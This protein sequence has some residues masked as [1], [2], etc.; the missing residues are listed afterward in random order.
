MSEIIG[1]IERITFQSEETGYTVAQLKLSGKSSLVC[2]VGAMPLLIPGETVR[3]QGE[4]KQHLVHGRQF[5]VSEYSRE[6]PADLIGIRK[7]LGSG[8]VKGIG[9]VYAKRITDCFGKDTLAIIDQYP[10]KLRDVPG[11][12]EKRYELIIA[13]W[14]EQR[15]VRDVMIFLQSHGITPAFSQKIYKNYGDNS[16]AVLKQNPYCLATDLFGIGFKTADTIAR[17][18]GIE[19]NSPERIRAG[20]QYVLEE[21]AADG[22]ACFPLSELLQEAKTI[23]EIDEELINNEI[24]YLARQDKI[25]IHTLYYEQQQLPFIWL[26]PLFMSEIGIARELTRIKNAG[27]K[28]R[29]IDT[30]RAVDWVQEKLAIVLAANQKIAVQKAVSEQLHIITGGPGTGKSTITKAILAIMQ[31]LTGQILLAA[32]T[33]R[34]AKRMTEITGLPAATIHSLLQYDFAKGGF[35]R[36]RENPLECDLLIVDESSMID[37]Y[38]MY[39]LLKAVPPQCRLIFVGDINQLPSVGPGN[40]LKDMIQSKQITVT[41]LNEIFRQAA[42]SKIITNSHRINSGSFPEIDNHPDSDF[43]FKQAENPEEVLASV[44]ALV[45]ERLPRKYGFDPIKD[46]QVLAPMKKGVI[47]IEN[48]NVVL[49]QK[50]NPSG[51]EPLVR[52]G[53]R[54]L[55]GDK[56][57]QIR[58]N[59]QKEV[60]NGDVGLISGI[61][62]VESKV[63][64][65]FDGRQVEYSYNSL[66]ELVLAYAVSVH[67][68]QG[69]ECPCII[70]PVHTS[71]FMMLHRNLLYTGVT[72]GK[73]LVILVGTQKALALAVN[74]DEVK[75][76]YTGLEYALMGQLQL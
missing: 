21:L 26:A 64:V 46:I 2:I 3:C 48:L 58:N 71:H 76:R 20:I 29:K 1:Y 73:K 52:Y 57:M 14:R 38:L 66:D 34:A 39:H 42:G 56:V 41:M 16:I 69:S 36:N 40:V 72:R 33:G 22:H 10:E 17:K 5:E 12:G 61:D 49:Q 13:C 62:P 19:A 47:G 59:Y 27:S 23:L 32:P 35:R 75:R 25:K 28:F 51:R 55:T 18:M 44:V 54:F 24:H 53:R 67:K 31:K 74:N 70:M 4:W 6:A 68:Y 15:A 65:V 9:P 43:F 45:K 30:A 50:L 11:I 63:I 37:T 7:Y 60:F 8:L